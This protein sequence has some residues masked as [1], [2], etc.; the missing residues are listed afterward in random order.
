MSN[1]TC[2]LCRE[3][4]V[5]LR[6]EAQRWRLAFQ[7]E[8]ALAHALTDRLTS[9]HQAALDRDKY[10]QRYEPEPVPVEPDGVNPPPKR[11]RRT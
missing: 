11:W 4:A 7:G 2:P 8:R 10:P 1:N 9:A 3:D 5:E 6:A